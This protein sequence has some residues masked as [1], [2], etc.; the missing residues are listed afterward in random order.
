M[1]YFS[2]FYL[3]GEKFSVPLQPV[4]IY[5]DFLTNAVLL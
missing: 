3:A 5:I 2:L 4:Q 1:H